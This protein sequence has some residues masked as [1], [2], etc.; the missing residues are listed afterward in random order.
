M[1]NEVAPRPVRGLRR[2][3]QA[4]RPERAALW[5]LCPAVREPDLGTLV[6][7][8][9]SLGTTP[10]VLLGVAEP[11]VRD[12]RQTTLDRVATTPGNLPDDVVD[13]LAIQIAALG[14][15]TAKRR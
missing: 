15:A 8:A 12:P 3:R 7:I 6:R 14:T 1:A 9:K 2:G 13:L 4:E 10:D 11:S 5:P